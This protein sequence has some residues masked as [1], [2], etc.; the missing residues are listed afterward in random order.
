MKN[1]SILVVED[2]M[3]VLLMIE[4]MLEDFGCETCASAAT[5]D[6][7]FQHLGERNF[8]AAILDINLNGER[9]DEIARSLIEN[10]TSF[11]FCSGNSVDDLPAQFRKYPFLRKPFSYEG[12]INKITEITRDA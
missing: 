2:E 8:D 9:S 4:D 1:L 3:M 5:C 10:G 6:Q 7:A 12:L 11:M